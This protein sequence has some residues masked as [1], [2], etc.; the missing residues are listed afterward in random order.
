MVSVSI[1]LKSN[2]AGAMYIQSARP[3]PRRRSS[4]LHSVLDSTSA[5]LICHNN[6][7]PPTP[8]CTTTPVPWRSVLARLL[9]FH[10]SFAV[11]KISLTHVTRSVSVHRPNEHNRR[12][13]LD[14]VHFAPSPRRTKAGSLTPRGGSAPKKAPPCNPPSPFAV[15]YSS[16]SST[17]SILRLGPVTPLSLHRPM[18]ASRRDRHG[19]S[20]LSPLSVSPLRQPPG[21]YRTALSS[22]GITELVVQLAGML[23][24]LSVRR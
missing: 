5:A 16:P 19:T 17:L 2:A 18:L 14:Q 6:R 4:C 12:R 8:T 24:V 1:N 11:R 22:L 20:H 3:R 7:R 23:F 21:W 9:L 15:P 13:S 10:T